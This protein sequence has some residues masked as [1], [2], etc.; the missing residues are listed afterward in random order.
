[1]KRDARITI[2]KSEV[3][4]GRRRVR[5]SHLRS[6][7]FRKAGQAFASADGLYPVI[8]LIEGVALIRAA[9]FKP[10]C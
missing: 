8:M 6:C 9:K 3:E 10:P 4:K 2:L 7:L 5:D 1:M